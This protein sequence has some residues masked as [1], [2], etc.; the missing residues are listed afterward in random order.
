M[1]QTSSEPEEIAR[2]AFAAILGHFPQLSATEEANANVEISLVLPEQSGLTHQVW[3][4]L[5]N[6]DELHFSVGNFWLEW[7]PC[8][9]PAKADSFIGAVVGFLAGHYRIL[10]HYRNSK[11]FK[12]ELQQPHEGSWQTIGTWSRLTWPSFQQTTY[13]QRIN[14]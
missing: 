7:F 11:C 12:A 8:T 2:R 3:L 5:Q 9:D 6:R 4:A 1:N 10:E 14:A 13:Q